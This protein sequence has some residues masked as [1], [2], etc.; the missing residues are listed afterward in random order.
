MPIRKQE[1][2]NSLPKPW[3]EDLLPAI[4][5]EVVRQDKKIIVLDDDPTGTQTV[6]DVAVFTQWSV[7]ALTQLL[8]KS[9]PVAYVLTNSRSL[10]R[11]DATALTREIA[12]NL[13][14]SREET[15]RDFVVISRSDS[16]LRGHYPVE[17]HALINGLHLEVDGV[18]LIPFFLEGGRLTAFDIHY[19][20]EGDSLIPAA[21]TEYA[22][23]ATFGY[24]HSNLRDWVS[25]KHAGKVAPS[26]VGHVTLETIRQG[27]PQA[28]A[29]VLRT[30]S[31]EQVCVINAVSYRDL[32]V[33]VAGLLKVE[34]EGN[35]FVYRT[36][37]SFVRVRGGIA[38]QPLLTHSDLDVNP[39]GGL[40]VVGSH[41]R[42]TTQQLGA[43]CALS[44]LTWVELDVPTLLRNSQHQDTAAAVTRD[45]ARAIDGGQDVVLYTSREP[46]VAYKTLTPLQIGEIVSDALVRILSDLAG[47][48]GWIVAK[49][50][51]T[52][53]VIATQA[54]GIERAEVL[55]QAIPGV[56]IWRTGKESRWPGLPYVVYPGNVGDVGALARMVRILRGEE[57][58]DA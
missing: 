21:E 18:L 16:T 6:H 23:D 48:P 36:A 40:I 20:T 55:G 9:D 10:S 34:A 25:E 50:G 22:V 12:G 19:V 39:G 57:G 2:F 32:E 54:L 28:V 1:F 4:R 30:L 41:V 33:F 37:A 51:I 45:V 43:L 52:S 8:E 31:N 49:G 17:V 7:P 13:S 44:D 3:S 24:T 27:G 26:D 38:P 58:S 46:V 47:G 14:L 11:E 5:T 53:S 42:K 35:R 29:D 15:G 56:P